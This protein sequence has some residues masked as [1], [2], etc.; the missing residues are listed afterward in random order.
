ML[1]YCKDPSVLEG[2]WWLSCY[3]TT[4][5]HFS[6]YWSI[7]TVFVLLACTAPTALLLGLGGALAKRSR[8]LPLKWLGVV[9][10]SIVRGVPDIVFFLF[11]PI[12]LDQ[13]LEF[14]RHKTLC[15]D[16]T[17]PVYQGNDF[18]VCDAAKFPLSSAEAWL[19]STYSFTLAVIAFSIVF[20]AFAA[21]V[22][23]GA[24]SAVPKSQ[25]E[26]AHAYGMSRRQVFTRIHMPQMWT[27]AL[28]GLSNLWMI[29]IKATPL[30]FLLGIEDIVYWASALGSTKT[31]FYEY[32]HPDWRI[33]YFSFLLA[34]YLFLTFISEKFFERLTARFS[35]GQ[36]TL[37]GTK[38]EA[39]AT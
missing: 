5:T 29:L 6:L 39:G 10:T 14:I 24:L 30:L 34:F 15:P 11:V 37:G 7:I 27:Y 33:W 31:S 18:I 12:A 38:N 20:G 35:L 13:A 25:L 22:I 17:D 1:S 3:L 32:P 26:T 23:D 36:A 21:N 9:Y 19:H 4:N 2:F 8:I 28:P 16:V